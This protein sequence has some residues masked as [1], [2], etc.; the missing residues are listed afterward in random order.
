MPQSIHPDQVPAQAVLIRP[1]TTD[2][3]AS[4]LQTGKKVKIN[5][6]SL[7]DGEYRVRVGAK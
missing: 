4:A 5:C 6:L 3:L 2:K 1:D 7:E